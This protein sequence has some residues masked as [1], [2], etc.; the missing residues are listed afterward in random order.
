MLKSAAE[1][2]DWLCLKNIHL[3]SSWLPNLEKELK[4]VQLHKNFRLWL[5]SEASVNF[6]SVLLDTCFKV[7]Y[8]SPPGLKKNLLSV[9]KSWDANFFES[10][11]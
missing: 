7:T 3:V 5:T 11:S 1:K 2:G 6:P 8:E 9:F 4:S 10:G